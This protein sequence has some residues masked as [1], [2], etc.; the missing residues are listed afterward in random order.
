MTC[1]Q[2]VVYCTLLPMRLQLPASL[3]Q[4]VDTLAALPTV[5][6]AEAQV[7]GGDSSRGAVTALYLA[8]SRAYVA[9]QPKLPLPGQRNILVGW[10]L[11]L[12]RWISAC[13][14]VLPHFS[15]QLPC[16][17]PALCRS[18]APSPT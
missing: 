1:L 13:P 8:D 16:C 3:G 15:P 2:V 7:L 11:G 5:K 4:Y 14:V 10:R 12:H 18:P 6:Q 9:A 17:L